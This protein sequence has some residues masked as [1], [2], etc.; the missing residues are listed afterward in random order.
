MKMNTWRGTDNYNVEESQDFDDANSSCGSTCDSSCC[1]Y[2][3]DCSVPEWSDAVSDNGE[4]F[5]IKCSPF[6]NES[7]TD[8]TDTKNCPTTKKRHKLSKFL[9]KH[10]FKKRKA[11]DRDRGN[12]NHDENCAASKSDRI[13]DYGDVEDHLA[14]VLFVN[15]VDTGHNDVIPGDSIIYFFPQPA[16]KNVV[17]SV[18]GALL[19][20]YHLLPK[21]V[22]EAPESSTLLINEELLHLVYV[23]DG[24]E[25]LIIASPENKCSLFELKQLSS[26]I[27]RYLKFRYKSLQG[28]FKDTVN[29]TS[30]NQFFG[31]L[32]IKMLKNVVGSPNYKKSNGNNVPESSIPIPVQFEDTFGFPFK[33]AIPHNLEMKI[34]EKLNKIEANDFGDLSEDC[35]GCQRLY[36]IIGTCL[37]YK[38]YLIVSHLSKEDQ[39]DV[40][41]FLRLN[42][43]LDLTVTSTI[44][45]LVIWKEVNLSSCCFHLEGSR[46]FPSNKRW[47]LSIIGQDQGLLITLLE[48]GG[49]SVRI[50]DIPKPDELYIDEL[51]ET[52]DNILNSGLADA[53]NQLMKNNSNVPISHT[54][55]SQKSLENL[56][57][58][59]GSNK[60]TLTKS[61]STLSCESDISFHHSSPTLDDA[62]SDSLSRTN[63][64][65][66]ND[67]SAPVLGRR[68]Q[69][70]KQ[71]SNSG[72][73]YPLYCS[74]SDSDRSD[75]DTTGSS[76]SSSF[77]DVVK[78]SK[79]VH[80]SK[81]IIHGSSQALFHYVNLHFN[82]GVIICPLDSQGEKN[83]VHGAIMDNFRLCAQKVR[84]VL[85]QKKISNI[86]RYSRNSL[87]VKEFGMLFEYN[88]PD[89]RNNS[90]VYWVVGRAFN[91]D[92]LGE[93]Y[94]CYEDKTPQNLVEIAF[95]LAMAT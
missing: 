86:G 90:T 30:L 56:S 46:T 71:L 29:H 20:L 38:G 70:M 36:T 54:N 21:L 43:L 83:L 10:R 45:S 27:V 6:V 17:H 57:I 28:C 92:H 75:L 93:I 4:L 84:H 74:L 22:E 51:Q 58:T 31:N 69:R 65:I 78:K 13:S 62:Y 34:E 60:N 33:L 67:D 68:A 91:K 35:Y 47:F 15:L 61:S 76:H 79:E 95:R 94:I 32:F 48:S 89:D 59:N 49:C 63:S 42:D 81:R 9:K 3:S 11:V 14:S 37:Y 16:V 44:E 85:S 53:I 77:A 82:N 39:L 8:T 24:K 19:T 55:S 1:E 64:S 7:S 26:C 72:N 66:F 23:E 73:I 5:F 50:D 40:H 41:A 52:L 80:S 88:E 18:R 2:H 12:Q 87:P 25:L